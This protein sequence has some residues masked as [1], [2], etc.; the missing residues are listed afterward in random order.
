MLGFVWDYQGKVRAPYMHFEKKE[1]KV[2]KKKKNTVKSM[3]QHRLSIVLES[4]KFI[5][6]NKPKKNRF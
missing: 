5:F 2:D 3:G 6:T 4:L 1:G